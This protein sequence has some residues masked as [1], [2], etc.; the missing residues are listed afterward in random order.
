MV[1]IVLKH[2]YI[3]HIYPTSMKDEKNNLKKGMDTQL[4]VVKVAQLTRCLGVSCA[5]QE[6][7]LITYGKNSQ[8]TNV[9]ANMLFFVQQKQKIKK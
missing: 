8:L 5:K 3:L 6:V 1:R 7:K 2:G 9:H 4:R